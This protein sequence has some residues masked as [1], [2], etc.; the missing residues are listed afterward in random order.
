MLIEF[1]ARTGRMV[2]GI[3]ENAGQVL[4]L[5]GQ[6]I[7]HL[8]GLSTT[9][10]VRQ[11]AHLGADSLPIVLLTMLFTGMVMTVQTG[12]EFV[13]YGAQSSVGG[14]VAVAMGRELSPVLTGVVF[15]GRVGAAITAEIGSMKV[16]EQI[17]ALRVM[18]VNPI[19]YLVVPRMLACMLM[20]PVLVIFA[21]GIG[22]IGSYII[23]TTYTGITSF[24][25]FNSIKV[26]AVPHDITGGLIKAMFFGAIIAII[27]CHKG[28]TTAQGAEGVGRATTG[29]VVLSII[30]IFISNYFLSVILYR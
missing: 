24:T 8:R 26:F 28:L 23:A 10:L 27:G 17:D 25:F 4:I 21:N 1:F 9:L 19:A 12:H 18:A 15:A 16:T 13:K 22:I 5:L 11:M 3:L 20:L 7:Y 2:I 29:S 14:L 6:S 30:L